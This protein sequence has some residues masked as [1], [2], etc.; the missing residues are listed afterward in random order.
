M[1]Q[2]RILTLAQTR[3]LAPSESDP[4]RRRGARMKERPGQV[5]QPFTEAIAATVADAKKIRLLPNEP[6]SSTSKPL[7]SSRIATVLGLPTDKFVW[8]YAGTSGWRRGWRP[9]SM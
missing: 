8:T 2:W 9:L 6:H 4:E 5:T 1:K 3:P 7:I